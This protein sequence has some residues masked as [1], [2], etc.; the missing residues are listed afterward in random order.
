MH[1]LQRTAPIDITR[2]REE[3]GFTPWPA[4]EVLPLPAADRWMRAAGPNRR[5]CTCRFTSGRPQPFAAGGLQ[6]RPRW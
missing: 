5:W 4:L 2:L 3:F 1:P 6:Q